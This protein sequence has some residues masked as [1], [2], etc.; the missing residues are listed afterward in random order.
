MVYY[1]L[2]IFLFICLALSESCKYGFFDNSDLE[3][4]DPELLEYIK[5]YHLTPPSGQPYSKAIGKI[6]KLF[7]RYMFMKEIDSMFKGKVSL[8]RSLN[9]FFANKQNS[10]PSSLSY[11]W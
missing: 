8:L 1:L 2:N 10:K 6:R 11:S 9:R 4:H 5:K 7:S 3:Q